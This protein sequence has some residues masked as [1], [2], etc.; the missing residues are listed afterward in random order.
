MNGRYKSPITPVNYFVFLS[1]QH[2]N[3]CLTDC[4]LTFNLQVG[5]VD[6]RKPN[7]VGILLG[8]TFNIVGIL[9]GCTF[10]I[11]GILLSCTFNIVGIL[12]GCAFNI[13]GI[14]LGC[15]VA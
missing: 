10:N 15:A 6:A 9:L 7:I 1:F 2:N 14:L 13:V 11:V 12:L 4:L 3:K 8:C 5:W